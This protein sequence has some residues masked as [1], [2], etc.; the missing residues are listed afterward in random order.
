MVQFIDGGREG[1]VVFPRI[2]TRS[3]KEVI[4]H[5][6]IVYK[7]LKQQQRIF[8]FYDFLI[9]QINM[10]DLHEDEIV[11]SSKMKFK[12]EFKEE[13]KAYFDKLRIDGE[14]TIPKNELELRKLVINLT[15]LSTRF[16]DVIKTLYVKGI[17]G[18]SVDLSMGFYEQFLKSEEDY[19]RSLEYRGPGFSN[20]PNF[21]YET[22]QL[23][24]AVV[25]FKKLLGRTELFLNLY[26]NTN[27]IGS[28][29]EAAIKKDF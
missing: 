14:L 26:H 1:F 10:K 4:N 17:S 6:E 8:W 20:T 27:F 11:Y 9:E 19:L 3:P 13:L 23:A 24:I 7:H 25:P 18:L 29:H 2:F 22:N 15:I 21:Y 12:E 28:K 5:V 16:I